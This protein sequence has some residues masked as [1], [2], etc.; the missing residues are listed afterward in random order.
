MI[1]NIEYANAYSEILGILRYIPLKDYNKIPNKKIK[2]FEK[3]AN[4]DYK[5]YFNPSKTLDEQNISK[6][7]KAI[8]GI[9]FRDYWATDEQR[10][11]IINKQKYDRQKL[12]EKKKEMYSPDSIFKNNKDTIVD[13]T[14]KKQEIALIE[15][16]D[17]KWY[18]KVWR[19]LTKFFRK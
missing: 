6:R 5:F 1:N 12:E 18:K 8:L 7:A 15:I 9:L 4:K 19:F 2:L 11:R 17:M 3:K 13:N 16:K 10:Q 14:E